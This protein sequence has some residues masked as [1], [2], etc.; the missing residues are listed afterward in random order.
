MKPSV[1]IGTTIPSYLTALRSPELVMAANQE[2]TRNWWETVREKYDLFIS[3]IVIQEASGGDP[4]A[5]MRRTAGIDG[6]LS[7]V[8]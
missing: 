1:Y 4:A 8:A 3:D 2:A 6:G 5:V 7:H